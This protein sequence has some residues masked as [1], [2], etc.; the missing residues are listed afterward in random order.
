MAAHCPKI[1]FNPT[2]KL[3][4]KRG[5]PLTWIDANCPLDQELA[6]VPSVS[7]WAGLRQTEAEQQ[8][9]GLTLAQRFR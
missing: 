4:A 7:A 8:Q 1:P 5:L 3:A 6:Q 2:A 9:R